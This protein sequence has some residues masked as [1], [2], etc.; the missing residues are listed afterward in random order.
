MRLQPLNPRQRWIR[1]AILAML[2]TPAIVRLG[3]AQELPASIFAVARTAAQ[4]Q[5]LSKLEQ[6][7]FRIMKTAF[8]DVPQDGGVLIGLHLQL[9]KFLD[10]EIVHAI[11]PIYLTEAGEISTNEFGA[12]GSPSGKAKKADLTRAVR[13]V[14]PRGFAVGSITV[15]HGLYIDGLRLTFHRIAGNALDT[16]DAA[17]SDWIGNGTGGHSEK[18]LGGDGTPIVGIFGNKDDRRVLALGVYKVPAS[19]IDQPRPVPR[20][21]NE[22]PVIAMRQAKPEKLVGMPEMRPADEAPA[23][24]PA[25]AENQVALKAAP[26]AG[27]KEKP[28][29]HLAWLPFGIFGCVSAAVLIGCWLAFDAKFGE[30]ITKRQRGTQNMPPIPKDDDEA[31]ADRRVKP[32]TLLPADLD[33]APAPVAVD[34]TAV[35]AKAPLPFSVSSG[36]YSEKPIMPAMAISPAHGLRCL[37]D[38]RD[39]VPSSARSQPPYFHA[40]AVYRLKL[41]QFY[42]VYVL[43]DMLLFLDAGPELNDQYARGISAAGAA[44]GGLLGA[45]LGQVIGAAIDSTCVDAQFARRRLLD[46]ADT[47]ELI[48]LA[49]EGGASFRALPADLRDARI[50]PTSTWHTMQFLGNAYVGLLC[51]HHEEHGDMTLEIPSENHMQTALAE[52]PPLFGDRLAVNVVLDR[53]VRGQT[54]I[55]AGVCRSAQDRSHP[56]PNDRRWIMPTGSGATG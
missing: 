31:A 8:S 1:L 15:R 50:E 33:A 21:Q 2:F 35:T 26:K 5:Q 4:K 54:Q 17:T 22:P 14:A 28:Q 12:F 55:S 47:D 3:N 46:T 34:A 49:A 37:E 16:K 43:P 20:P 10:R 38:S 29:S 56:V 53:R 48:E 27:P 18:T 42:R 40:R 6:F 7:G 11:K 51:F 45:A 13:I 39:D 19:V 32:G 30:P 23:K 25:G 52:L 41:N 36:A 24:P 9:G 44:A